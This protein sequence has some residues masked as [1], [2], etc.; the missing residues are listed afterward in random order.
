MV[1]STHR[2]CSYPWFPHKTFKLSISAIRNQTFSLVRLC[3]KSE[4][5]TNRSNFPDYLSL[6]IAHRANNLYFCA[7]LAQL[8][9]EYF[10]RKQSSFHSYVTIIPL[11]SCRNMRAVTSLG[12]MA[13]YG[14][15]FLFLNMY[16]LFCSIYSFLFL[17]LRLGFPLLG[18]FLFVIV[19]FDYLDT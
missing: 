9:Y 14:I 11:A 8:F 4:M 15:L 3:T 18:Q 17:L 19:F 2:R 7:I 6:P 16:L 1:S 13:S 12:S 5:I 10:I